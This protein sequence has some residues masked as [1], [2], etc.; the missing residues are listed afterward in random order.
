MRNQVRS[1]GMEYVGVPGV[2]YLS[3]TDG[4][5]EIKLDLEFVIW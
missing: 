1:S 2:A 4:E 3:L 5:V